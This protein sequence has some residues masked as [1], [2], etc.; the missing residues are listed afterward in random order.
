M[1]F[2]LPKKDTDFN[3]PLMKIAAGIYVAATLFLAVLFAISD[4]LQ[5][6]ASL[7][8]LIMGMTLYPLFLFRRTKDAFTNIDVE[9]D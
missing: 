8:T 3:L 5:G 9:T 2:R 6:V 7:I 4:P 1:V